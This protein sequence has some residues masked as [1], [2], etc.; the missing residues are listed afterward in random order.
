MHMWVLLFHQLP[1]RSSNM[2]FECSHAW[3]VLGCPV[4]KSSSR[5]LFLVIMTAI[6]AQSTIYSWNVTVRFIFTTVVQHSL[7]FT[8]LLLLTNNHYFSLFSS[9]LSLFTL[10][11]SAGLTSHPV[12]SHGQHSY[13]SITS[14]GT[15]SG[16][17]PNSRAHGSHM[18]PHSESHD[19][20]QLYSAE[21]KDDDRPPSA[22]AVQ[23]WY[24]Y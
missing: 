10:Q 11:V 18:T 6:V 12:S 22:H 21:D 9:N 23:C 4:H 13:A 1:G 3:P 14:Q 24:M 15:P 20:R 8:Y 2:A 7:S 16:E 5:G 17:V 19:Q